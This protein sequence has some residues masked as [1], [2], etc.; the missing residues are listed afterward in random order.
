MTNDLN[1]RLTNYLLIM[2]LIH[3]L[4]EA[5]LPPVLQH[6]ADAVVGAA[7]AFGSHGLLEGE[8]V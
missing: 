4:Y 7:A 8:G 6:L 1:D 5:L 2:T 3:L